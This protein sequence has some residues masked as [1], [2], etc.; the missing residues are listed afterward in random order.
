MLKRFFS[1]TVHLVIFFIMVHVCV[2]RFNVTK[3]LEKI[4]GLK[5]A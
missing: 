5:M 2:Q 4:W 3:N 1:Q